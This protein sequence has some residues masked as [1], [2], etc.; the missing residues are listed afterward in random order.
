MQKIDFKQLSDDELAA[1]RDQVNQATEERR[2]KFSL[3]DIR[4]GMTQDQWAAARAE[5]ARALKG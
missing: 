2:A 4:P 3:D 1:L 5:I